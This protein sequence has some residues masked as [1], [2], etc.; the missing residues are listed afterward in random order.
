MCIYVYVCM[1]IC[2]YMSV[3]ISCVYFMDYL[4][5]PRSV[6]LMWD[7]NCFCIC[8]HHSVFFC[9]WLMNKVFQVFQAV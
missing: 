7:I 3:Y 9:L 8:Q 5:L 1:R 4:G 6:S 2:V